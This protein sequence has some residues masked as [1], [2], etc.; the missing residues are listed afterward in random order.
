M[1][2]DLRRF[3]EMSIRRHPFRRVTISASKNGKKKKQSNKQKKKKRV[4]Y[5]NVIDVIN[6]SF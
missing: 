4:G 5:K 1:V 3:G 2:K 6:M